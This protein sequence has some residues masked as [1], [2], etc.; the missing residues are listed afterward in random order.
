MNA[1]ELFL[2]TRVSHSDN[3]CEKVFKTFPPKDFPNISKKFYFFK[4]ILA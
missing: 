3:E 4:N 1:S 2:L